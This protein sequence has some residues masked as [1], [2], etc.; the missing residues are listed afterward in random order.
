M[1]HFEFFEITI[2]IKGVV[3]KPQCAL[4]NQSTGD[5]YCVLICHE[6]EDTH[7]NLRTDMVGDAQC[8]DATCHIVQAG[9][10]VCTY[11]S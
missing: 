9:L 10:G 3:A 1:V 2:I 4:Q 11:D 7:S 5:K 8:G 6:A